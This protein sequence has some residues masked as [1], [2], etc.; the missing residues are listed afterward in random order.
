MLKKVFVMF[1]AALCLLATAA[2]KKGKLSG[3]FPENIKCIAVLSPASTPNEKLIR[4]GVAMLE[5][6]GIK[7]KLYPHTFVKGKKG[8]APLE[9]RLADFNAAVNDPEV[10][11]I[12]PGRGGSGANELLPHIDWNKV[13]ERKLILMGFSNITYLTCAMDFHKAGYPIAGPNV[14]RLVRATPGTLKHLS[15][16]LRKQSPEPITLTPLRK[17]DASGRVIAGHLSMLDGNCNSKYRVDTT[18]RIMFIECVRR[19]TEQMDKHFDS[20]MKKG[21]FKDV[22]A[23]VL[24]HFTNIRDKENLDKMFERW[25]SKLSCPVYKGYPYGHENSNHALDYQAT[26]VIKDNVLTFTF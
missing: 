18:G 1:T 19:S 11:M 10:D 9:Q 4:T 21:F 23:V 6:A 16:V 22:K 17:G 25:T 7:V 24:C 2:P 20:M 12:I 5:E 14:G 13:R 8:R 3:V 15:C 26:A